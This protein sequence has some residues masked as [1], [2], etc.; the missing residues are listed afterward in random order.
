MIERY[1]SKSFKLAFSSMWT[2]NF[3]KYKLDLGKTEEPQIKLPSFHWISKKS[4]E[5][6]PKICFIDYA[7]A[8]EFVY[9]NSVK[10]LKICEYQTTLPLSW[11]TCMMVKK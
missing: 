3:Q 8:F 11:E 9:H 4:K 5:F 7:K 6:P 1:C 2:E 10:S